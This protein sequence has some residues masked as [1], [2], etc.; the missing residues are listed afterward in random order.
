MLITKNLKYLED[1]N[2]F[3]HVCFIVYAT[4]CVYYNTYT[5]PAV[6]HALVLPPIR[7]KQTAQK[8]K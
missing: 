8:L 3:C 4:S 7:L 1:V 2:L 6:K 5:M